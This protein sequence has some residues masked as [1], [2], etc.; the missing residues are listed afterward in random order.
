MCWYQTPGRRPPLITGCLVITVTRGWVG[1]PNERAP[2]ISHGAVVGFVDRCLS[3]TRNLAA[4]NLTFGW[5]FLRPIL[6]Q[7]L[8]RNYFSQFFFQVWNVIWKICAHSGRYRN[9]MAGILEVQTAE[10][11]CNNTS[12]MITTIRLQWWLQPA[13]WPYHVI[14]SCLL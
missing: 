13:C 2:F 4:S 7:H 14:I 8:A 6:A 9:L 11:L 10:W 12:A 5:V 3:G 1:A